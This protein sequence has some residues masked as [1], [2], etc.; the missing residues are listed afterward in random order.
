MLPSR[1][2]EEQFR[3]FLTANKH[4]LDTSINYDS[5]KFHH[6]SCPDGNKTDARYKIFTDSAVGGYFQ[7][8]HCNVFANFRLEQRSVI[9]K[10]DWHQH[11]Q[12]LTQHK[13]EKEA[14]TKRIHK[15][16]SQLAK[17][18]WE[19]AIACIDHPYL[20]LKQVKS[21]DLRMRSDG[22]LLVPCYNAKLDLVNLEQIYLNKSTGK[23]DKR[24]LKGGERI[25]A[26]C[27]IGNAK[28]NQIIFIAE[29]YATAA[30]I[31]EATQNPVVVS[32]NCGNLPHVAKAI[33]S[34]Y[35]NS[36]IVIA[37]DIDEAGKTHAKKATL[38]V[39]GRYCLPDFS[40]IPQELHQEIKRSDFNDLFVLLLKQGL[41][42][43]A[44][45]EQVRQIINSKMDDNIM[46]E[47]TNY[48]LDYNSVIAELAKLSELE[49]QT[50]RKDSAKNLG[51]QVS[52]LDKLVKDER[53]KIDSDNNN[54]FPKIE[55]WHEEI[56][57]KNLLTSIENIINRVVALPSQY[58]AK[59][60]VLWILH[61]YCLEAANVSPLLNIASPE[62]RCGKSTLLS[63]L[64]KLVYKPLIASNITSSAL[65]RS[66]EKWQPTL[67]IDEADTFMRDNEDLRGIINSGHTKS[68]AFVL[69]CT[70]DTHEPT[71]FCTWGAKAIAGIGH[72]AD[73]LE[74]RSIMIPLR[75]KLTTEKKES[76][77][78]ISDETFHELQRMCI[79]F[80]NDNLERIKNISPLLPDSL[81]DR[82]ADNWLPLLAIAHLAGKEY[83][84]ATI[85]TAIHLS[86]S[87]Q[88]FSSVG[89]DLLQDIKNIFDT[90]QLIRTFTGDLLH[91]LCSD[92]EAPWLTYNRGKPLTARQLGT[93]LREYK[94]E[95]KDLRIGNQVRKGFAREQFEDAWT[96]YL[97]D[98][99]QNGQQSATA[100]QPAPCMSSSPT[101]TAHVAEEQK[102]HHVLVAEENASQPLSGEV[103]SV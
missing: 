71:R 22:T 91:E 31:H 102:Q 4:P 12:H 70:G 15:A 35:P 100:L 52:A 96:R 103:C 39:N 44:A 89:I 80:A 94:I 48:C 77:R 16:T 37:A 75:R 54:I 45:L 97:T 6:L 13:L 60:I 87:K 92:D 81:N 84:A 1:E 55:P 43:T 57:I 26:F 85:E 73:T 63:I 2:I 86:G 33:Q 36:R 21:F 53:K 68:L 27:L 24:P 79:R 78:N 98:P 58:E 11:K 49:Y 5:S 8:W 64:Q 59:A 56:N 99:S 9:S 62:K 7:C 14:Q 20:S 25:G 72:L 38:L 30:T 50:K 32:F 83:L 34:L 18:A 90:K 74:D 76:L 65:F 95:S 40:Q 82:A 101:T 17:Q 67:L 88:A 29:G 10:D 41:E 69:R 47:N 42:R 51:I 61:T 93:R 46:T 23:Y 66:V 19:V 28:P 3:A